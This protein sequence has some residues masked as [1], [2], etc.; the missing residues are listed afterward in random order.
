[1][2]LE[3]KKIIRSLG[4][5]VTN[6][7]LIEGSDGKRY[8]AKFPGNPE[9]TK[10]LINEF[11]C[12]CLA[13]Y[14]G[15]PIPNFK[16]A[17]FKINEINNIGLNDLLNIDG[18]VFCSE[19]LE[20]S[21]PVPDYFILTKVENKYD[22]IKTL[23]FDVL[24]GNNDRNPGNLLINLKNNSFVIIDHSH[25]F[26]NGAIWD[27]NSLVR[28]I[29]EPINISDMVKFTFNMFIQCLNFENSREN[30]DDFIFKI[31]TINSEL[32]RQIF[33]SVPDDWG[34][35]A[36]DK[37]ALEKFILNRIERIKEICILL[38]IKGGD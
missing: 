15:L 23:V 10:V 34:F 17:S 32:I 37:D 5:G 36:K 19:Y 4:L 27:S 2:V 6:P 24:I 35:S 29:N 12:G 31:K 28:T 20:K 33:S 13:K 25:V 3:I 38:N 14:L 8:V 16:I 22:T 1:M 11:V 9:G 30:L 7:I 18:S 26:I 21:A